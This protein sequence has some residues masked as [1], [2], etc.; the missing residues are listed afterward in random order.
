MQL[1]MNETYCFLLEGKKLKTDGLK[2]DPLKI[3]CHCL[4]ISSVYGT[5]LIKS[6]GLYC[7]DWG[8]VIS[9]S[10]LNYT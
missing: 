7:F 5:H 3:C 10:L 9:L 2:D 4:Y 6:I 8:S 1:F